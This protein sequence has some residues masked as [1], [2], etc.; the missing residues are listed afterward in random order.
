MSSWP[1]AMTLRSA[2]RLREARRNARPNRYPSISP[3]QRRAREVRPQRPPTA[4]TSPAAIARRHPTRRDRRTP[5]RAPGTTAQ[6]TIRTALIGGQTRHPSSTPPDRARRGRKPT[7][8]PSRHGQ[9]R[10]ANAR[11]ANVDSEWFEPPSGN[12]G[13]TIWPQPRPPAKPAPGVRPVGTGAGLGTSTGHV[14]TGLQPKTVRLD[15]A[16]SARLAA[17]TLRGERHLRWSQG[18]SRVSSWG[19]RRLAVSAMTFA[20]A[21]TR[22]F[23]G[24]VIVLRGL[25]ARWRASDM[26][27]HP[28][29]QCRI[30][31]RALP[32]SRP[33]P[34]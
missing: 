22:W 19:L 28:S 6:V 32:A 8:P 3:T 13:F 26:R 4:A 29:G 7:L 11:A 25:C 1:P 12:V 21:A 34:T 23:R 31:D 5:C 20:P 17:L 18:A 33:S 10:Y 14:P 24:I 15:A 9:A 2:P 30:P 16:A 27:R